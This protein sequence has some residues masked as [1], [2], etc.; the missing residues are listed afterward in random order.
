MKCEKCGFIS[1][2]YSL[3]CKSCNR[4]LSSVRDKLGLFFEQPE[5]DLDEFFTGSS[6][7]Y[8]TSRPAAPAAHE[9][10]LDLESVDDFDFTLDD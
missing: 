2:D 10:E 1:F 9:A 7:S 3:I 4:D 8:R 5:K 6:G